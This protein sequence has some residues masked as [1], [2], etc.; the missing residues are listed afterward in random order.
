MRRVYADT[1]Y[2]LALLNRRDQSHRAAIQATEELGD[3]EVVTSEAVLMELLNFA[4]LRPAFRKVAA[5]KV[6]R[7]LDNPNIQVE[8]LTHRGFMEALDFYEARTDKE[9]SL[10]DCLS[11]TIMQS[12]SIQDV[13]TADE[14]FRQEG[15]TLLMT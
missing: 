15:F 11:M 4:R 5:E 12:R 6:R 10:V 8:P 14:H 3:T 13:L 1:S 2:W 7:I 9:Y